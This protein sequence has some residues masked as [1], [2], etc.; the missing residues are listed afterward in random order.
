MTVQENAE[1]AVRTLDYQH[2]FGWPVQWQG[3]SLRLVVGSGIG[4]VAIPRSLADRVLETVARQGCNGPAVCVLTKHGSVAVLLAEAD[5]LAPSA[6]MLPDGVR[7]L[8]AG[9][10]VPLPDERSP[11]DLTHWLV[12]PDTHQRWLPSL[13]AVLAAVRSVAPRVVVN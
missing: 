11:H 7:V 6:D 10:T 4:A 8:T 5:M 12:P 3:N 9:S 2:T 13:T 1:P